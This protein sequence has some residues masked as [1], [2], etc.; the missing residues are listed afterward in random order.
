MSTQDSV[1]PEAD[2]RLVAPSMGEAV[3]SDGDWR[4]R[5]IA[6]QTTDTVYITDS[7]GV[8]VYISP[9][10]KE[11]FGFETRE[12]V[13]RHFAEF[14]A[15]DYVDGAVA[16]FTQAFERDRTT[17]NL[18]LGMK[19]RDGSIFFGELTGILWKEGTSTG[20]AG[21]IR[22]VTQ[23]KKV[24]QA[25]RESE[26]R[27]R[28]LFELESN[29]IVVADGESG[30]ILEVNSAAIALYGYSRA[31]FLSMHHVDI[32]A[33]P[34]KSLQG[35]AARLPHVPLRWHRRKDGAVFPVDLTTRHFDLGGRYVAVAAVRDI[36]ERRE[37][38]ER[39]L[40]SQKRLRD[41]NALQ[42]RLL[43]HASL[44]EKLGL[45]T[46][47]TV[48]IVEG[49]SARIWMI[50]PGDRCGDGC[51]HA[52]VSE[53]P[54]AC[55]FRHR[56]L[57]LAASFGSDDLSDETY[58]RMPFGS[59]L[60]GAIAAEN[61]ES[62]LSND[63][64]SDPRLHS[65]EWARERGLVSF[66]G[67]RLTDTDYVPLGVLA[68]FSKRP[69]TP[70]E[71]LILHGIAEVTSHVIEAARVEQ[72][73]WER[74]DQ[75]RQSQKMEAIG[76]LAGGIAH[77]F[78]NLLAAIMGYS[79]LLLARQD[80]SDSLAIQDLGEIKNAAD[81]ASTLTKQIL[82]FSRRQALRPTVVS[83]NEVCT[84]MEPLLRRT[85]GEDMDLVLDLDPELGCVEADVHQF[86]QV[87]MNL[88]V[89]ARDAMISGGTLTLETANVTL[90]DEFCRTNPH[91][92]CG[93]H[94]M[95]T[96]S[97]TGVGIESGLLTRI[98]EP[99]F[100]TKAPGMGTGLGLATVYGTV[101][102]SNGSISVSSEPGRGTTFR[103]YLP[104]VVARVADVRPMA[105]QGT[106]NAGD[107]T[108][109]LVEDEKALRSLI[110]RVLGGLGYDVMA[111]GTAAEAAK[112]A[113]DADRR[114]DLLL[115]DVVL[116]GSVQGSDLARQL[117]DLR[118]DLRVLYIS[119]YPRDSIVHAGR[120]D[121]GVDFLE[122]PFTPEA[123]AVEVRAVLDRSR[124]DR[125]S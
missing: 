41:F 62:Y 77:D 78:N 100:T 6:E 25:L 7:A 84:G 48:E 58:A 66:A 72:A 24:E 51:V 113:A 102:Q 40:S 111:G 14:L 52:L 83:L 108:I 105:I 70:E 32:S 12:M 94:V 124:S 75:L 28:Q 63:L 89:N 16:A 3:A 112:I 50:K 125:N 36:T 87:L 93:D 98:F 46:R 68:L 76:Q 44:E 121:A 55:R 1:G 54:N 43:K 101:T 65:R 37:A 118:P 42:G 26:E 27:Y 53:G 17:Q 86:E 122:K 56:C 114:I 10:A 116:P 95:M 74:D 115:T 47:A 123:L 92:S 99:F 18:E 107:E 88:A 69:I 64:T 8:I 119:G 45:V 97:D 15:E 11:T 35:A 82:A 120:L 73:L 106:P 57:H 5:A 104:R 4:F 103:I 117:V 110:T 67:Y 80:H 39:L 59:Y 61:A 71:D 109:L 38:E 33:E 9:A 60:V 2:N 21:V 31:E 13:G 30:R 29:A 20:T 49:H 23:R 91:I 22:D 19:R 85:L 90:D 96:V 81:R 34:E 79:E